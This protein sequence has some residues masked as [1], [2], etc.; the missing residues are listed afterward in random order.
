MSRFIVCSFFLVLL[1]PTAIDLY[2]VGLP[3]IAADLNAT[4]SQLHIAFSVYL[5]G[6]AA[7]MLLAGKLADSIGRKP[8]AV[9]GSIIFVAAS[10]LGGE[11]QQVTQF[12]VARFTQGV[13]A[14]ACYVVAFAVLRD[15][16][17]DKRR[18]KA[19]SVINGI[20]CIVPV[21]A[22]VIG[23]L[24]MLSSPWKN[25]FS[26]M[27]GMGGIVFL[28]SVVILRETKPNEL[29]D[30]YS[31]QPQTGLLQETFCNYHFIS[32]VTIASLSSTVLLTY[33]NVSP[34]LIMGQ[35]G[36]DREGYSSVIAVT[37][38]ISM[39]A[40]FLAPFALKHVKENTLMLATQ[41]IFALVAMMLSLVKV[42][43]LGYEWS[44][45]C[46]G[47]I[48]V[49]FAMGYGATMNQA[50]SP[51]SRRS[52]VASSIVGVSQVSIS[53]FYIWLMG[54][55][56]IS[57]QYILVIILTMSSILC[58]MLISFA[59]KPTQSDTHEEVQYSS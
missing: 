50:L 4:E 12:L 20:I 47:L 35:L 18:A 15:T 40:S 42:L 48:C 9:I 7:T 8:V 56:N 32:R 57:A 59:P 33:V 39:I 5:G 6:M 55:C 34:I 49:A 11:A 14:G 27:A 25:L 1:Y 2:L 29:P 46:F 26:V 45:L 23:H 43:N 17:D 22:P 30:N 58:S 51:Y 36:F 53:A 38:L 54:T 31:P 44:L 13:G 52:G 41:G 19:L 21:I 28:L 24:I 16:L 3:Q 37:S 10:W